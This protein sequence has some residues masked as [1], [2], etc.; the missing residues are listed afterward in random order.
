MECDLYCTAMPAHV[1]KTQSLKVTI[2]ICFQSVAA[3]TYNST[4]STAMLS[5]SFTKHILS[6]RSSVVVWLRVLVKNGGLW[7]EQH[8]LVE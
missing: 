6:S 8:V 7:R 1:H 2:N 3:F 4:S 5:P